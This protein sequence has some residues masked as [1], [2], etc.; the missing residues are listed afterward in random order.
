MKIRRSQLKDTVSVETHSGEG[1]YGPVYET[2]GSGNPVVHTIRWNYD[3][4][5][6]L[7]RGANG[8]EVVSEGTGQAHPDDAAQFTPESRLT[9]DGRTSTVLAVNP[10]TIRG[11][12]HHLKVVCS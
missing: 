11:Q 5:R 9:I 1:A 4:T 8:E 6:R 2:D 7:V 3:G 10:Q 12:M